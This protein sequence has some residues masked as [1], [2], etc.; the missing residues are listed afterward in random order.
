[1]KEGD[2]VKF[3]K[4]D[5]SPTG[6]SEI[7]III[8]INYHSTPITAFVYWSGNHFYS[9]GCCSHS[10]EILQKIRFL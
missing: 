9:S 6:T 2:L 7:G 5:I 8:Y 4:R 3:K 10:I 1:M